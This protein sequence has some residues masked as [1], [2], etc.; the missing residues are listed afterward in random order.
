MA[1]PIKDS[2]K[3]IPVYKKIFLSSINN[4]IQ[5]GDM[6]MHKKFELFV[7]LLAA[8]SKFFTP[9]KKRR[10][11]WLLVII[12]CF[13]LFIKHMKKPMNACLFSLTGVVLFVGL[14][15]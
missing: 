10:I 2:V 6:Y 1:E 12:L 3:L 9:T 8:L 11:E 13:I 15:E 5:R 4:N 7:T 14:S